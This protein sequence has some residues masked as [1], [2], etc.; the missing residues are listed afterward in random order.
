MQCNTMAIYLSPSSAPSAIPRRMR[1][2]RKYPF[3]LRGSRKKP[4]FFR[5]ENKPIES[6]DSSRRGDVQRGAGKEAPRSKSSYR[7]YFSSINQHLPQTTIRCRSGRTKNKNTQ[8]DNLSSLDFSSSSTRQL[9][10]SLLD[11]A[12]KSPRRRNS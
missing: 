7:K 8:E 9:L 2:K 1:K 3:C 6:I 11:Q 5:E 4:A 10:L 12:L